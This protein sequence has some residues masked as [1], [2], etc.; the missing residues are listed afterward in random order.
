MGEYKLLSR[1]YH[2][3]Q[4]RDQ[5]ME[6]YEQ[7]FHGVSTYRLPLT[8]KD[9]TTGQDVQLFVVLT[10]EIYEM[11]IQ[12]MALKE[13]LQRLKADLPPAAILG[14]ITN[15]ILVDELMKNNEIEGVHST[16]K[17]ISDAVS[18]NKKQDKRKLR[19]T[20]Q[21]NQYMQILSGNEFAMNTPEQLRI[22][23]D[24]FL[25][26]ELESSNIPDGAIFRKDEVAVTSS[27]EKILH[28]GLMP[29][30]TII[31]AV[32]DLINFYQND[33][34]PVLL[35]IAL[36]HY[37]FGY[38][39]PFYDG[40]GR[41]GRL[42][43]SILLAKEF[44]DL[45][46]LRLSVTIHEQRTAYYKAFE[47]V[48]N[49]LNKGDATSFYAMFLQVIEQAA[50]ELVDDLTEKEAALI[51]AAKKAQGLADLDEEEKRTLY[52]MQQAKV[53]SDK[54]L[55]INALRQNLDF[56]RSKMLRLLN[57][58]EEKG[59]IVVDKTHKPYKYILSDQFFA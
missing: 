46:A 44:N 8:I 45:V 59:Y 7:R 53:F 11:T 22:L 56:S 43:S 41:F 40:N 33:A 5:Y 9:T 1:M 30:Q 14:H 38:I 27:T 25:K 18:A 29:E 13:R 31:R 34:Y 24:E 32:Q 2:D 23:Y 36:G 50:N 6:V 48:N 35:R 3:V 39:H 54:N 16:R 19:F 17:E 10:P 37:Y 4:L 51:Y 12:I 55:S 58:I 52:I 28:R 26:G 15:Y 20:N 57:S 21:V 49:R 42:L 47:V